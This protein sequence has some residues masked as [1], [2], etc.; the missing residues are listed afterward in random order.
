MINELVTIYTLMNTTKNVVI[1]WLKQGAVVILVVASVFFFGA[2][3]AT[4]S[5]HSYSHSSSSSSAVAVSNA[6]YHLSS[7][8]SASVSCSANASS[9]STGSAVSFSAATSGD[10]SAY[11]YSWSGTDGV[12]GNGPSISKIY[13]TAGTKT[14]TVTATSGSSSASASCSVNVNQI[15]PPHEDING[16]CV[17]NTSNAF[18]GDPINWSATGVSGGNGNYTYSWSGTDG[19]FGNG[20]SV[21]KTYNSSGSKTATLTITSDGQ[22]ITRSCSTYIGSIVTPQLEVSCSAN[23]SNITVGTSATFSATATGG[24]GNYSYSWT[25]TDGLFGNGSSV[26]KTYNSE[27]TKNARVCV[28]SGGSCVSAYCSV[29]VNDLPPHENLN[30]SCVANTSNAQVGDT[31]SWSATGVSGGNGNYT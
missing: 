10:L 14:V 17:A 15:Q 30:G 8:S 12:S 31:V 1:P 4:A 16:S 2:P 23:A 13:N 25:G 20:S 7:A 18:V 26:S 27:G 11:S 22:H 5:S 21:S 19:L 6:S 24:N 28:T 9:V 29:N 3:T